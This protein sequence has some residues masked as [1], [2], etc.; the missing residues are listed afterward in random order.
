MLLRLLDSQ[1]S[2]LTIFFLFSRMVAVTFHSFGGPN[3]SIRW[4]LTNS[5]C[6]SAFWAWF[7]VMCFGPQ[8]LVL[9]KD[10]RAKKVTFSMGFCMFDRYCWHYT[11]WELVQMPAK[12]GACVKKCQVTDIAVTLWIPLTCLIA[13]C[14]TFMSRLLQKVIENWQGCTYQQMH[15]LIFHM[16]LH[17][18][19]ITLGEE[20][21]QRRLLVNED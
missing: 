16:V 12:I 2:Q 4:W 11:L 19:L 21:F 5:T 9:R 6:L 1:T 3:S 8:I 20:I 13:R 17:I 10:V 14:G 15:N 18:T 7:C